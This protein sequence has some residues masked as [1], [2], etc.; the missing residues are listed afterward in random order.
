MS[1]RSQARLAFLRGSVGGFEGPSQRRRFWPEKPGRTKVRRASKVGIDNA[2]R[3]IHCLQSYDP[4]RGNQPG[5]RDA[6]LQPLQ[7]FFNRSFN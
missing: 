2:K 4:G 7:C 6:V 5:L 1:F 3:M